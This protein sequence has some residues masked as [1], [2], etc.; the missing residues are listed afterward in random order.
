[1]HLFDKLLIDTGK[2]FL[3]TEADLGI[4]QEGAEGSAIP[5][6]QN[7]PPPVE[8]AAAPAEKLT[9]EGKR[10]LIELAL[11]AL[12]LDPGS[13]SEHDKSLFNENVTAENADTILKRIQNLV[14]ANSN[15]VNVQ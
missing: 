10:Y 7:A 13:L 11:K 4:P 15:A 9:P 2:K 6:V 12:A 1:M 3:L 8:P 5:Q 14:D